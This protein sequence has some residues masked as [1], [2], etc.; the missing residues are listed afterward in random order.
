MSPQNKHFPNNTVLLQG[1]F[2]LLDYVLDFFV[3]FWTQPTV[4]IGSSVI[5]RH[6]SNVWQNAAKYYLLITSLLLFFTFNSFDFSCPPKPLRSSYHLLSVEE[7]EDEDENI[8]TSA[9][10]TDASFKESTK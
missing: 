6:M 4:G 10:D 3:L 8:M 2:L 1:P 7:I 5:S 9:R